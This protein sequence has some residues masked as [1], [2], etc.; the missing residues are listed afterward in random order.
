MSFYQEYL[1]KQKNVKSGTEEPITQEEGKIEESGTE[2]PI[3]QEEGKIEE[4]GTEEPITQEE[5]KIEESGIIMPKTD[6]VPPAMPVQLNSDNTQGKFSE[7]QKAEER[8]RQDFLK[9]VKGE[10][11]LPPVIDKKPV[12]EDAKI[13]VPQKPPK[14]EKILIRVIVILALIMIIATIGLLWYRSIQNINSGPGETIKEVVVEEIFVSEAIAPQSLLSY[15]LFE[16]PIITSTNELSSHLLQY[17]DIETKEEALVKLM[18]RDQ[19][20]PRQPAFITARLFLNTF[21]IAMPSTFGERIDQESFN[22]FIHSR[23]DGN[24]IGFAV[25]INNTDGFTGMMREWEDNAARDISRFLSLIEKENQTINQIFTPSTYRQH[26]IRCLEF[27]DGSD[28]CYATVREGSSD[29]FIFTTSS[30]TIRTV[31]D[32]L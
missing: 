28:I 27:Q 17:M 23:E 8:E 7:I 26:V 1:K 9:R 2:E 22:L 15:D 19:R 21:S 10:N 31:I 6:D 32:F 24:E 3:T 14:S 29:I 25:I 18:F 30:D 20:D 4:S 12:T 5:G 11:V 13:N 16:Y